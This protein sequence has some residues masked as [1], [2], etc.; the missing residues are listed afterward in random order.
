MKKILA[1]ISVVC[2]MCIA[3]T[4]LAQNNGAKREHRNPQMMNHPEIT[5]DVRN[6]SG[7]GPAGMRMPV[8]GDRRADFRPDF[9]GR[10]MPCGFEGRNE[11]RPMRPNFSPDMPKEIREKAVELAKLRI[12]LEEALTSRPLNKEKALE[13]FT[14]I[15]KAEQEIEAWRFTRKLARI[16]EMQKRREEMEKKRDEIMK[17]MPAEFKPAPEA[18]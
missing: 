4:A 12:D 10:G 11:H 6:F 7:R 18:E 16:E 8:S 5:R 9:N 2:V 13:A 14:L 15:Q 3:G 17:K 1:V